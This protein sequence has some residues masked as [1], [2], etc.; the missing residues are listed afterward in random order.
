MSL[1]AQNTK[2]AIRTRPRRRARPLPIALLRR[3][4]LRCFRCDFRVVLAG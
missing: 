3:E 1:S 4:E 2:L